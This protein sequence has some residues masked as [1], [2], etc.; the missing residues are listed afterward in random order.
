MGVNW[1]YRFTLGVNGSYRERILLEVNW[2]YRFAIGVKGSYREKIV[3]GR[4]EGKFIISEIKRTGFGT[5]V[6]F[7]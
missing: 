5:V 6:D 4:A 1:S 7:V 2:N 3:E